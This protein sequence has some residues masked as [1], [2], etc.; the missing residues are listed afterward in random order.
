MIV[1]FAASSFAIA[2]DT[3]A[4]AKAVRSDSDNATGIAGDEALPFAESVRAENAPLEGVVET[5]GSGMF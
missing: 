5:V 3:I 2:L 1:G 4:S